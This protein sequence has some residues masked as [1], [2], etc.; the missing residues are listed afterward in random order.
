MAFIRQM[1]LPLVSQLK[2]AK[3]ANFASTRIAAF[4]CKTHFSQLKGK[5]ST[6]FKKSM[7]TKALVSTNTNDT[8]HKSVHSCVC[9]KHKYGTK[10]FVF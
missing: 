10:I 3:I 7:S 2:I 4:F 8:K 9:T 5:N 6:R 1:L